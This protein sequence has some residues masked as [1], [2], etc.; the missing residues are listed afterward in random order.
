MEKRKVLRQR[1][2]DKEKDKKNKEKEKRLLA[3]QLSRI[4]KKSPD[5][6]TAEEVTRLESNKAEVTKIEARFEKEAEARDRLKEYEEDFE[7]LR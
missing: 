6:R 3:V 1:S 5:V 2:I 7:V 4:L